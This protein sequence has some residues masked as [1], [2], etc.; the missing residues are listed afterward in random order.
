MAQQL[1]RVLSAD[2]KTTYTE[3]AAFAATHGLTV[4]DEPTH[5]PDGSLRPP[6]RA[7]GRPV[8]K[9]TSVATEAARKKADAAKAEATKTNP[10]SKEK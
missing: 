6:T 1:V 5:L 3:G 7:N 10:P 2:G 8:K 4:V 9:K